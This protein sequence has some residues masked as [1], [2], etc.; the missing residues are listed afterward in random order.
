MKQLYA[1][2]IQASLARMFAPKA[3]LNICELEIC[4]KLASIQPPEADKAALHLLHCINWDK[5]PPLTREY[6]AA[7]VARTFGWNPTQVLPSHS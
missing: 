4:W 7:E 1:L 5:L 3:Y 6:A 2:A